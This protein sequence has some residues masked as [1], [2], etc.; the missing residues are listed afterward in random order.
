MHAPERHTGDVG[1]ESLIPKDEIVSSGTSSPHRLRILQGWLTAV[2]FS[3]LLAGTNL[4]TPLLPVYR[5]EIGF[6]P[7]MMSMSFVAYVSVLVVVLLLFSNRGVVRF[8]PLLVCVA[9]ILAAGSDVVLGT[10]T[11]AGVLVGRA[12]AGVAGGI[13]TGAVAALVVASLGARGRSVSATGNLIGAVLGTSFAQLCVALLGAR[14]M[15]WTFLVHAIVCVC[16]VVVL[17]SVLTLR[18]EENRRILTNRDLP[19]SNADRSVRAFHVRPFLGGCIAWSTISCAIVFL[20]SFFQ[21]LGAPL[22]RAIGVLVLLVFCA[23]GQIFS[24]RLYRFV[25][26]ASGSAASW[27][28]ISLLL[29]GGIFDNN[30]LSLLGFGLLGIGI[31]I[32]YRIGLLVLTLGA[33]PAEQSSLSSVYAATTYCVAATTVLVAGSMGESFGLDRFVPCLFL[34]LGL[35]TVAFSPWAPK[36]SDSVETES[37]SP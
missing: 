26:Q 21:S 17:A 25:P 4:T 5:A 13:G 15:Y 28:G 14:A 20:P 24:P 36:L 1:T 33:A 22:L 37:L 7:F 12:L 29:I 19:P 3:L 30:T 34:V 27:V 6:T 11:T 10:A 2:S 16:L 35:I 8:S 32:K 9:L 18:S 31:G 23:L